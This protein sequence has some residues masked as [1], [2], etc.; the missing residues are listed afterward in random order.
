MR[1]LNAEA[2][3]ALLDALESRLLQNDVSAYDF[4]VAFSDV[5]ERLERRAKRGIDKAGFQSCSVALRASAD[6]LKR[7]EAELAEVFER[8]HGYPPESTRE[9]LEQA[10]KRA[11]R[12][13][14]RT[15]GD[16]TEIKAEI[17]RR[18]A[19]LA[20]YQAKHPEQP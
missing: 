12:R 19:R 10:I 6:E 9:S 5:A 15:R 20:A 3:D 13:L 8:E 11:E 2:F 7:V 14:L 16:V 17:D 1:H 4:M 18:K